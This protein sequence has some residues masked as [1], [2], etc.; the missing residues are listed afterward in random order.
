MKFKNLPY[1]KKVVDTKILLLNSGDIEI[2]KYSRSIVSNVEQDDIP[3]IHKKKKI[4]EPT[5]ELR[6][7][8]INRSRNE[9]INIVL[10][11]LNIWKSFIT[12]TFA[13][14]LTR[15]EALYEWKK[16]VISLKRKKPDVIILKIDEFTGQ[17]RTHF[18]F[19]SNIEPDTDLMPK[20]KPLRL[21]RPEKKRYEMIDYYDL[22]CWSHGYSSGFR[23]KDLDSNFNIAL[24]M[25][26]YLF[27]DFDNRHY[28]KRKYSIINRKLLDIPGRLELLDNDDELLKETLQYLLDNGYDL[29]AETIGTERDHGY[30][31]NKYSTKISLDDMKLIKENIKNKIKNNHKDN[32]D[33][34]LK[35]D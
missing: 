30:K 25:T 18:H 7:D 35:E 12:L 16:Y 21:W 26:K 10:H 31:F 5:Y 23:I 24:Y 3:I 6:P 32:I 29:D 33:L 11:N 13:E 22:P 17:G 9:I 2:R 14:D 34:Y 20:R 28:G 15:E 4:N 27:K 1:N 8:N 19:I